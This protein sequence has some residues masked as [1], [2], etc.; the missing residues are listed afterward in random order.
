ML[1]RTKHT[2][3]TVFLPLLAFSSSVNA[4]CPKPH[5]EGNVVL[6]DEAVLKDYFPHGSDATLEC[7]NGYVVDQGSDTITCNEGTWSTQELICKKKDCGEPTPSA[8]MK[9]DIPDGTLF[10]VFIRPFC[11]RGYYLQGSSHRQCLA[12]GW[13]GRSK[14]ILKKCAKPTEIENGMI[15]HR[16]NKEFPEYQDVLQYSCHE[17]YILEG[18]SSVVCQENGLYSSPPPQCKGKREPA[19]EPT[20]FTPRNLRTNITTNEVEI[21]MM[22]PGPTDPTSSNLTTFSA[23]PGSQGTADEA[24][25]G[26]FLSK[27]EVIGIVSG[28]VILIPAILFALYLRLK[29]KG[30]YD[31]GEALRTKEEL[32]QKHSL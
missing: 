3:W 13:T 21:D 2:C 28:I 6:T 15:T 27:T 23:S 29:R 7:G 12:S 11:D 26:Q 4:E 18:N 32:L 14:C 16:P 22:D 8:N 5:L 25:F 19:S 31:T 20:D 9:Y 17:N 1:I 30:S 24:S 10:G